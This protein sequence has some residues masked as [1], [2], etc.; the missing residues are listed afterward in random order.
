MIWRCNP[1]DE[2]SAGFTLL[3][4]M[5]VLAIMAMTI[6]LFMGRPSPISPEIQAASAARQIA[7]ALRAARAEAISED[8]PVGF[9]LDVAKHSYF[10][11]NHPS[12]HLPTTLALSLFAERERMLNASTGVIEFDPD[13]G[14]TG[15]RVSI[16]AGRRTYLVGVD[17]ISGRV[18]FVQ[19]EASR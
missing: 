3:E 6:G 12:Q 17:W 9:T 7:D 2:A 1:K 19:N 13:G 8:R 10:W 16:S 15:G 18:S 11:G 5:V 4:L 14:A